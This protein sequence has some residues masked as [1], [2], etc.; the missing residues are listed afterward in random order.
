MSLG[1]TSLP[2]PHDDK[3]A[4]ATLSVSMPSCDTDHTKQDEDKANEIVES[5]LADRRPQDRK[6]DNPCPVERLRDTKVL[7]PYES[8]EPLQVGGNCHP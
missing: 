5:V 1:P 7:L 4:S 2:E 8:K 3:G 6:D